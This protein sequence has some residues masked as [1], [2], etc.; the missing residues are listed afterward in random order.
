MRCLLDKNVARC[1]IAGMRYGRVRPL[2]TVELGALSFWSLAEERDVSLFISR[3]SFHVLRRLT[4][5]DEVR[6]LLDSAQIL[7]PTRYHARWSRR[8]RETVGLTRE[9]AAMIALASFGSDERGGILGAHLLVTYDQAMIN[10]YLG[11]Y[12]RLERR[13][14]AMAVQVPAPF[15]QV[16]LPRVATPDELF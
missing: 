12:A 2:S 13:L 14:R 9:D 4:G 5:Y 6:L 15:D 7:S 16:A 10:R 8:I 11:R 1:A 3:A